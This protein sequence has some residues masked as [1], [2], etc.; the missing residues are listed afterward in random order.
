MCCG[1][2]WYL[3]LAAIDLPFFLRGQ[4]KHSLPVFVGEIQLILQREQEKKSET[5]RW[6]TLNIRPYR[7][8]QFPQTYPS[9]HYL[10]PKEDQ[11]YD[12]A[13]LSLLEIQLPLLASTRAR[14]ALFMLASLPVHP[15]LS[16]QSHPPLSGPDHPLSFFASP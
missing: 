16:L 15:T 2:R 1:E 12:G 13:I 14:A 7:K 4:C 5:Q 3:L 6:L 9:V 8:L 10:P 11:R